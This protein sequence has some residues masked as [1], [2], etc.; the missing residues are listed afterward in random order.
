MPTRCASLGLTVAAA[1]AFLGCA[2]NPSMWVCDDRTGKTLTSAEIEQVPLNR[3]ASQCSETIA[4]RWWPSRH[5]RGLRGTVDLEAT[6]DRRGLPQSAKVIGSSG[7][8]ALEAH[9]LD[10]VLHATCPAA[11][12]DVPERELKITIMFHYG[13]YLRESCDTPSVPS[14]S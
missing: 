8:V 6:F 12:N 14:G 9:A 11:P 3:W 13:R 10:T 2:A 7:S 4:K 5:A 1:V